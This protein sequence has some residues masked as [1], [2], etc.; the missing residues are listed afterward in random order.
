[1]ITILIGIPASGKSTWAKEEIKNKSNTLRINRDDFRF[2]LKNEPILDRKQENLVTKLVENS[3]MFANRAGYDCIIDQT[4]CNAEH[5]QNLIMYCSKLDDITF[6]IFDVDIA[7]CIERDKNR[8]NKVGESVIK[9]MYNNFQEIIKLNLQKIPRDSKSINT[10]QSGPP[11]VIFDLD[12]TLAIKTPNRGYYEY[13]KVEEDTINQNVL[14]ALKSHHNAGHLILI[15]SGR[16]ASCTEHTK[17][18]LAANNIPYNL[19]VLRKNND[20]RQDYIIKEELF[21]EH[22]ENKYTVLGVYDDRPQVCRMW[23]R[24]GLTC[25]QLDDRE[26]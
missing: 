18:W 11:S 21:R 23:R 6:K 19:L 12:G 13:H 5:L 20:K 14:M 22:I 4:N 17:R 24:I 25:Y 9:R 10:R 1:M 16:D 3:I 8:E 26:F 2:M 7:T 15:L